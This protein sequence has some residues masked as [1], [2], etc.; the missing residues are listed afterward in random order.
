MTT[1]GQ[2]KIRWRWL[3]FMYVYTI[4]ISAGFGLAQLAQ[5]ARVQAM[6]GMPAQD[7]MVFSL[8]ASI[9]LAFG[10]VAILG[11]R[12]PLRFCPLLL[13]ELAYKVIWLCGVVIPLAIRGQFP[14]SSAVEVAIF[15]TF[16]VGDAIAIP[17]RY[18]FSREIVG[19]T[20]VGSQSGE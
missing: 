2:Y 3:R 7:P 17:F 5:P 16:V 15:V 1:L 13:M 8:G 20:A 19:V 4:I 9:F 6:F 12:A 14:K 11:L 18:L 10:L